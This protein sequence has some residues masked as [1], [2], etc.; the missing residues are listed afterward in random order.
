MPKPRLGVAIL[1]DNMCI[2]ESEVDINS[3]RDAYN[4]AGFEVHVYRNCD[5]EVNYNPSRKRQSIL[6]LSSQS[7]KSEKQN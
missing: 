6:F 2:P 4:T 7:A 1:I 3:L 5:L